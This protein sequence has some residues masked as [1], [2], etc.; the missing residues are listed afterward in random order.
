MVLTCVSSTSGGAKCLENTGQSR[1]TSHSKN[2]TVTRD[3]RAGRGKTRKMDGPSERK[4]AKNKQS[5]WKTGNFSRTQDHVE[6]A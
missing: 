4:T 2:Q 6:E 5:R 1:K 3:V